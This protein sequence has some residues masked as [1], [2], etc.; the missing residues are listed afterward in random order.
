MCWEACP[1]PPPSALLPQLGCLKNPEPLDD[2]SIPCGTDN[3]HSGHVPVP[4]EPTVSDTGEWQRRVPVPGAALGVGVLETDVQ[5]APPP[6]V[7]RLQ[8]PTP[9]AREP[10]VRSAR[11][12]KSA[13]APRGRA[14]GPRAA[15][16]AR[17]QESGP[18]WEA[19]A[20][21]THL[22]PARGRLRA[23]G[24]FPL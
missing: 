16:G 20:L 11:M 17:E 4:G 22:R 5:N 9:R 2:S 13:A 23:Q 12:G 8:P 3:T 10:G 1:E 15:G 24:A 19:P 21:P 18:S 14:R 6:E 7:V